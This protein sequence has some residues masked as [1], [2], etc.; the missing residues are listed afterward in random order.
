MKVLDK[1]LYKGHKGIITDIL[2]NGKIAI[3]LPY[4]IKDKLYGYIRKE[5]EPEDIELL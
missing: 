4:R 3:T 1:V 2:E 5:V